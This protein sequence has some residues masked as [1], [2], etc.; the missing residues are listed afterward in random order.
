MSFTCPV[1]YR[2]SFHPDDKRHGYCGFCH[3]FTGVPQYEPYSRGDDGQ[4]GP[5]SRSAEA[6]SDRPMQ[7][8]KDD[9]KRKAE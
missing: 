5:S 6:G 2:V 8:Q 1:C 4:R 3:A 7:L 9:K